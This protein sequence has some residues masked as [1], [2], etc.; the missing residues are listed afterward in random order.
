M[1]RLR[2]GLVLMAAFALG[3]MVAP[4]TALA[5]TKTWTGLGGDANWQTGGNWGGTA[6]LAGDDLVFP[7]GAAQTT[8]TNNFPAGT[9]FNS[10]AF[11]GNGYV[12]GGNR[13]ALS[14]S[15]ITSTVATG[16]TDT[17]NLDVALSSG[18]SMAVNNSGATLILGGATSGGAMG[19]TGLGRYG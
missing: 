5:A 14:V 9:S 15:G 19:K 17:L 8:N 12:I 11:S 4:E 18:T 10:L 1:Q 13:I 2:L 3:A 6:P 16:Q 7:A